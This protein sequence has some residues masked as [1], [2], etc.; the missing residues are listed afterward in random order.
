MNNEQVDLFKDKRN[1]KVSFLPHSAVFRETSASTKLRVVFL[2]NLKENSNENFLSHNQI[3][4]PGVCLNH[5]L[6]TALITLLR[7]DKNL[8][9]FDLKK[10]FLQLML[11]EEDSLKLRFL[12]F[13]D[14]PNGDFSIVCYK[15][16]RVPFG[17]RYSPFLLMISLYYMLIYV[18]GDES[19]KISNIKRALYDLAYVDNLAYTGDDADDLLEAVK[20]AHETFDNYGFSLQQFASNSSV[21]NNYIKDNYNEPESEV[22]LLGMVWG[23][24]EDSLRNRKMHLNPAANTKRSILS[25]IQ[26]N[27]DPFGM[28]IPIMNR[29]KLFMHALQLDNTLKWDDKINPALVKEWTNVARQVNKF[30]P[31]SIP[32]SVG[33]R[34]DEYC[35]LMYSD[36]SKDFIGCVLY[37]M[38]VSTKSVSFLLARNQMVTKSLKNKSIP[39]LELTALQFGLETVTNIKEELCGAVRPINI[40]NIH[41]FT[42]SQIVLSWIKSKEVDQGK[43]DRKNVLINNKLNSISDMCSRNPVVFDHIDGSHNPADLLTRAISGSQLQNTRF[44]SG[45]LIPTPSEHLVRVPHY[46]SVHSNVTVNAVK[47]NYITVSDPLLSLNRFSSF[48]KMVKCMSF[49]YKF[50]HVRCKWKSDKPMNYEH[51]A[52]N[53]IL[54]C[55]QQSTLAATYQSLATGKND[56]PLITQMNLF[57]DESNVIR[58]QSKM[59]KLNASFK[60]KCPVLLTKN[61]P[62]AKSLIW[63]THIKCKHSGI[64]K[65]TAILRK[66]FWITSGFSTV[67]RVIDQCLLCRRLNNR[68]VKTNQSYYRDFR[69]NPEA[70][71]FRNICI[72]HCGPFTVKDDSNAN[73]KV[74][75]LVI[76]CFWSRCVN[77]ILCR[78]LDTSSFIRALQIHIHEHGIPSVIVSDNGSSIVSGVDQ[79]IN[80]LNN[81]ETNDFLKSRGIDLMKFSPYPADSSQLGGFIESLVKQVKRLINCS[82]GKNIMKRDDF[83]FVI[84]ESKMLINKRPIAFKNGLFDNN[85]DILNPLTPEMIVKGR[86]VACI[87]IV[88]QV[89]SDNNDEDFTVQ[90][91]TK[92]IS[93][94]YN[95]LQRVRSKLTEL[96]QSEFVANLF[97]QAID[98]KGRYDEKTHCKLKI[99]DVVCIKSDFGKPFDYPLAIVIDVEV[100][101]LDEVNVVTLR[102]SNHEIVR[103]HVSNVIFL[104]NSDFIYA[105]KS[106][107]KLLFLISDVNCLLVQQLK[108]AKS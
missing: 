92:V 53:Y 91:C 18:K 43:I 100:N 107:K 36:A 27:F 3:S 60:E 38:N 99:G 54:R 73:E 65:T 76:S 50:L 98:R 10:A 49:V 48:D 57:L 42:D 8:V 17:M 64:Y 21:A 37:L 29:A 14:A 81:S 90:N 87:N 75:I 13:R 35:I 32:R 79:T 93:D 89:T 24:G 6:Q 61:C 66:H 84:S 72:D 22:K 51:E 83:E 5:K 40:S 12:W 63:D 82:V 9:T 59:K 86:D 45:P 102:K 4:S 77:L 55:A 103:R 58:I 23:T 31:I 15:M 41:A 16:C 11:S 101:D 74:Y 69:V 68:T 56:D 7:F 108:T 26:S 39:V 106:Q 44:F 62:I 104:T 95:Q 71:P 67:K 85:T 52:T 105:G 47:S 25:S 80:H 19:E 94:R 46:P 1:S 34:N 96:Y 33:S 97:Q 20:V 70:V 28:N 2:S 78:Q 88:P 30:E